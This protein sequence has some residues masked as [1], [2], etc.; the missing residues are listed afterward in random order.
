MPRR[1]NLASHAGL[2]SNKLEGGGTP[3]SQLQV[4]NRDLETWEAV[5]GNRGPASTLISTPLHHATPTSRATF[6]A[7][8]RGGTLALQFYIAKSIKGRIP[9]E[10]TN[11]QQ[12]ETNRASSTRFFEFLCP[13]SDRLLESQVALQPRLLTVSCVPSYLP[14]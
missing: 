2:C 13:I 1:P 14:S 5:D 11:Y 10:P 9:F 8:F 12:P 4:W 3:S 7:T 6:R